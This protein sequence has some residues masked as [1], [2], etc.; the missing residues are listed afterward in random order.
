MTALSTTT[1]DG[2]LP[3]TPPG[4]AV[5]AGEWQ[6]IHIYYGAVR[7]DMLTR[8][9]RPMIDGLCRDGLLAG[10]FFINYWV[11]G[12]HLRLR[13]KPSSPAATGQVLDRA[14]AAIAAY[15]RERPALYED[16]LA[17]HPE[18][19][20]ALFDLEFTLEERARYLE[21][22]GRM[23]IRPNNSFCRQPYEPEYGRYGGPAGVA[24]AEWHF[25]RSSDAVLDI[26][27]TMNVH[28]RTVVL[29][30]AAQL[31][32]VMTTAFLPAA[33]DG[34]EFLQRYHDYWSGSLTNTAFASTADYD[35]AY[36][37]MGASVRNRFAAVRG[38]LAQGAGAELPG[39]LA[40]WSAHCQE[41]RARI[42]PLAEAGKLV[43]R[44]WDG[45]GED[46]VTDPGFAAG[47]LLMAYLHMTNNRLG[48]TIT[49][50]SYLAHILTR[51]L[52]EDLP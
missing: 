51:A 10:Y 49:D 42:S 47:R 36:E 39:V 40:G 25:Q 4:R 45:E 22:D 21:P 2:T 50:E 28:L 33:E 44:A 24:L 41:L 14:E 34:A 7:Q 35:A 12:P 48:V 38:A 37:A 16:T 8:S 32:M 26:L 23:R 9:I 29:G 20:N 15:L 27:R 11:E 13:L 6:A 5:M 1:A 52:R 46:L 43:F 17:S 18:L 3:C 19:Y 30:I 31:M